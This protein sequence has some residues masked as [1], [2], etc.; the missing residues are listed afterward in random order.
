MNAYSHYNKIGIKLSI[1]VGIETLNCGIEV[2]NGWDS[3]DE[4][5][6]LQLLKKYHRFQAFPRARAILHGALRYGEGKKGM[7]L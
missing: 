3:T 1:T 4:I 2:L 6:D 5:V 7:I